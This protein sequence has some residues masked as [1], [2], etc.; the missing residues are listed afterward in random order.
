MAFKEPLSVSDSSSLLSSHAA[1]FGKGGHL[2]PVIRVG[3]GLVINA[4]AWA[5]YK[6]DKMAS[7]W[8]EV[9]VDLHYSALQPRQAYVR[10]DGDRVFIGRDDRFRWTSSGDFPWQYSEGELAAILNAA[11]VGEYQ[12]TGFYPDTSSWY[13]QAEQIAALTRR[14]LSAFGCP[15][16][17]IDGTVTAPDNRVPPLG[18]TAW[19]YRTSTAGVVQGIAWVPSW[20]PFKHVSRVTAYSFPTSDMTASYPLDSYNYSLVGGDWYIPQFPTSPF[21]SN[22]NGIEGA[23]PVTWRNNYVKRDQ[24]DYDAGLTPDPGSPLAKSGFTWTKVQNALAALGISYNPATAVPTSVE[25]AM[26]AEGTKVGLLGLQISGLTDLFKTYEIEITNPALLAGVEAAAPGVTYYVSAGEHWTQ[27]AT[28]DLIAAYDGVL[29]KIGSSD[30]NYDSIVA[31]RTGVEPNKSVECVF[32]EAAYTGA[33]LDFKSTA[34]YKKLHGAD[35]DIMGDVIL[36]ADGVIPEQTF[37][38]ANNRLLSL[39]NFHMFSLCYDDP[40]QKPRYTTAVAE[41]GSTAKIV[42]TNTGTYDAPIMALDFVYH[43]NVGYRSVSVADFK[44]LV[45]TGAVYT[46]YEMAGN[47]ADPT[48]VH[49][50][51][52]SVVTFDPSLLIPD[53]DEGDTDD[54]MRLDDEYFVH[55]PFRPTLM[56]EDVLRRLALISKGVNRSKVEEMLYG[57]LCYTSVYEA[58]A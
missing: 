23:Y 58:D 52:E 44:Y 3:T 38:S 37:Q 40:V 21:A 25:D 15:Q 12:A 54:S 51:I 17:V 47:P 26:W 56:S 10:V 33:N 41:D 42:V 20:G 4:G 27:T 55:M 22:I 2:Q 32:S 5:T 39:A 31:Q 18:Y 1:I 14:F 36:P 34:M 48:L 13:G 57:F 53:E 35:Y 30:P 7:G 16:W 8:L 19:C 49:D 9:D 50:Y 24:Y 6:A 28:N 11:M 46:G 45:M 29:S 43:P